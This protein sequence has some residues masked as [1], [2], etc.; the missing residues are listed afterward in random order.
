LDVKRNSTTLKI[1]TAYIAS[2]LLLLVVSCKQSPEKTTCFNYP[3]QIDS[4]QI[5]DLYDTARLYI[6]TWLCD[7][8]TDGY[9]RGQFE[10]KYKDFFM[11]NDTIELF[12]SHYLP[13]ERQD[14]TAF[15]EY[16]HRTSIAFNIKSKQ[17]LWG[18]DINGF[19][20]ALEP[21][22]ARFKNPATNEVVNFIR[23]HKAVLDPCFLELAKRA[24]L[25]AD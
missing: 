3:K 11:R 17:K 14:T 1:L 16:T 22:D 9:Y 10:L 8:K 15:S 12:F 5:R 25:L 23:E 13:K 18:W 2:L 24:H 19:S 6:F 20:D 7:R 4:L 21:S